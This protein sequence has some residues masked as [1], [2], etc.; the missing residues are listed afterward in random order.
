MASALDPEPLDHDGAGA[1]YSA[2]YGDR[3]AS[4]GGALG[5]ARHVFL[6]GNHLPE[7]WAGRRQFVILETGFGLG[8][9][10]LAAWQCW[11]A[12]PAR[13]GQLHFVSVEKHPLG[14][15]DIADGGK[16]YAA[17]DLREDPD[18]AQLR[19]ALAAQ[20]PLLIAGLH[21]L[22]FDAGAVVLT[23]ALGDARDLVPQL[24]TGVDAFF[25]DGFAP[26][27][28][29]Q[30]WEPALLKSLAR[31]ARPQ[32][33]LATYS[34]A[35]TVREALRAHGFAVQRVPGFGLKRHMLSAQFAPRWKLRRHEPPLAH[36]GPRKA[37]VVGA[38]IAGCC[39]ALA[40]VR[41]GWH[42]TLLERSGGPAGGASGLPAGLVYPLLSADDNLA[43]RL[44]RAAYGYAIKSLAALD[45]ATPDH[46][47][48]GGAGATHAAIGAANSAANGA[49]N[50]GANAAA[51]CAPPGRLWEAC[52]VFQQAADAG[53][54]KSLRER[55]RTDAWP[56]T[57]AR[58][59]DA[60][61]A[62]RH[63]GL[64]P[65]RG[66]AWFARGA[67]VDAGRWCGAL[68][69]H[70]R[71][72]GRHTGGTI[73][74]HVDF[75][76]NGLRR[77]GDAWQLAGTS[78]AAHGASLDAPVVVLANAADL[79]PLLGLAHL[80]LQSIRGCLSLIDAPPLQGL[81]A[82]VGG[83]GYVVPPVLGAAAVGATYETDWEDAAGA[84]C[85]AAANDA[86][87]AASGLPLAPDGV[88]AA[89]AANV[90]RLAHLLR[91][92]PQVTVTGEFRAARCV[93]QDRMPLAGRVA[94]ERPVLGQRGH[95]AGAHLADLPRQ[96]GLFCLA[97]MGSRGLTLAPLLGELVA[98]Q[99]TGEPA[100]IEAAL[101]AA[102]DPARFLLR[103][104]RAPGAARGLGDAAPRTAA[105]GFVAD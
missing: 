22:E 40:L 32:A 67:V 39:C 90:R 13:P 92:P 69:A 18:L 65:Q 60:A 6:G 105:G 42:V 14:V 7:R 75:T 10:F 9:N 5:Q 15:Q 64:R 73:D 96:D 24:V 43:S 44:S 33:T 36:A 81:R 27:R 29:P 12:D 86:T 66:G 101:C 97:A 4:R 59:E 94:D 28:N 72:L 1:P 3:Y 102:V 78:D 55:L 53:E 100:P 26:E 99:I 88:S 61:T 17:G 83:E 91:D 20:W 77:A 37:I 76:V 11:R 51:G 8:N 41:R 2:R 34:A 19:A 46:A 56:E 79:A 38:G 84:A 74:L 21:R 25:L 80:P 62:A 45:A 98:A 93:S 103:H 30:M 87:P 47:A 57:F 70:A 49:A 23:L 104:L 68:L 95:Y 48:N 63:L 16:R 58:F 52:G 54:E 85:A 31:L 89:S 50:S 71:Q 82:A 35:G